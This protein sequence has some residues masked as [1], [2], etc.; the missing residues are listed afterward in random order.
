MSRPPH[1]RLRVLDA[2]EA[3]LLEGGPAALVLEAVA[4]RAGVS[5]GGLLYH[6]AN[7]EALVDGLVQRML[8]GFDAAQAALVAA[9]ETAEGRRCRAYLHST[10]DANG[11][12]VDASARLFAGLLACL[13]GESSRLEAVRARFAAWQAA[14]ERDG[15]DPVRATLLRL[16]A[17][18][19]WL[20]SLLGHAPLDEG[21]ARAVIAELDGWTRS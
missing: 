1:A 8:D 6:F 21:L 20:S 10:V 14:L 13:G 11:A 4:E 16:A 5:K 3:L 17:D 19:L 2:A 18:G 7:K 9:D 15:V 12:P